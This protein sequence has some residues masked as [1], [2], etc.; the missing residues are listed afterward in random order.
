MNFW[1]F[2]VLDHYAKAAINSFVFY[3]SI[4]LKESLQILG[5][6]GP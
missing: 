6:P 1:L 3:M 4:H 5:L 2:P